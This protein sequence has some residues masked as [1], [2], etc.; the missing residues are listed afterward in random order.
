MKKTILLSIFAFIL[1]F[2]SIAQPF[3]LG[4]NDGGGNSLN[5]TLFSFDAAT[6]NFNTVH[7]FFEYE[8]SGF[9][10]V[11]L[12]EYNG[13]LYGTTG[14]NDVLYS[15][16]IN[17][18]DYQ[19]HARFNDIN[20][21]NRPSG[22]LLLNGGKIYGVTSTGGANYDGNIFEFDPS[23]NQISTIHVFD[24]TTNSS[25]ERPIGGLIK[26]SNGKLYGM[27]IGGGVNNDGVIYSY[28]LGTSTYTKLFDFTKNTT[29]ENPEGRLIQASN[30][31]LYGFTNSG[32]ANNLGTIFSFNVSTN[33]HA[34]I[35][36]FSNS[37]GSGYPE[38]SLFE[39]SNSKLYG[40]SYG[41]VFELDPSNNTF[42]NKVNGGLATALKGNF[43]EP[44][45]GKLYAQSY[46]SEIYEYN[47]A[48]SSLSLVHSPTG[49][50][51][52]NN[53]GSW[54][55]TH[56]LQH[57]SSLTL[58]SNGKLYGCTYRG[59]LAGEGV[60]FEYDMALDS[61]EVKVNFGLKTMSKAQGVLLP[62]SNG[63][64][65][66]CSREG[67]DHNSGTFFEYDEATATSTILYH[68]DGTLGI[69]PRNLIEV[70]NVIYGL[71]YGYI[72][73]SSM[74]HG[75]VMK[76]DMN[77]DSTTFNTNTTG[78]FGAS[79]P[80]A[81]GF[82]MANN[83]HLYAFLGQ[84]IVHFDIGL[85]S[86]I[87]DKSIFNGTGTPRD[88]EGMF[89]QASDGLLYGTSRSGGVYNDGTLFSYNTQTDSLI[90]VQNLYT[91][92][93]EHPTGA[94]VEAANGMI[95]FTAYS[96]GN[97]SD[98][99]MLEHNPSTGTTVRKQNFRSSNTGLWP[100]G[101]ITLASD[102]NIYGLL[103]GGGSGGHDGVVYK[104]QPGT[105]IITKLHGYEGVD[106]NP[107]VNN[108]MVEYTP[109]STA[110]ES[111]N[112]PTNL[113][114]IYPNPTTG[115]VNISS[116]ELIEQLVVY[117][118]LGQIV[119]QERIGKIRTTLDLNGLKKGLYFIRIN[120]T[121]LSKVILQ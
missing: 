97:Y 85:D 76:Y 15:F 5:G 8:G 63:K 74:T 30:G 6:N 111:F 31:L 24:N 2:N 99:T 73:G 108:G 40:I 37:T 79:N 39:A 25:G 62:A 81:N 43:I 51:I 33:T 58:A 77:Q 19:V 45:S 70:N 36:S 68:F 102:G 13:R 115:T 55:N 92:I 80:R 60:I 95:Y 104:Y 82:T 52:T 50:S 93:G 7:D 53:Y 22:G 23:N 32:G 34:L 86:L 12:L 113:A 101:H 41:S 16:S 57:H 91:G 48:T 69:N 21:G 27:T 100:S 106:G 66:G 56:G 112:N 26:A 121:E 49:H 83:G 107:F 44:I 28:D 105:T 88:P 84:F 103:T 17:N 75:V 1:L 20:V 11:Q 65:Y 14:G 35:H 29:G 10:D 89:L 114:S 4:M 61:M 54:T 64:F 87:I 110:L 18:E 71:G 38:F 94:P 47:L 59:G 109:S 98:G 96:G 46:A 117:N 120:D 9:T 42:T 78:G 90:L 3:F 118:H 67:G 116:R 72:N 119:K